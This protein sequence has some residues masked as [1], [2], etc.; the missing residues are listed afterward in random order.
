[1]KNLFFILALLTGLTVTKAQAQTADA[2]VTWSKVVNASADDVWT[3][4]REMDD[5]NKYSSGISKVVW[6]GNKGKGGERIC[7]PPKGQEGYFKEKIVD[8]NDNGRTFSYSVLEGIP[9][10]GMVNT[11]KVVDL[12]YQKS[13]IVWSSEF[14]EFMKNPQMTEEQFLGF[15]YMSL[16]EMVNN[17][18]MATKKMK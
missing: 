8:F 14:D 3:L 5:I 6:K 7:Y 15:I 13:M 1:M 18:Y 4:L 9:V 12:G 10:K 11:F 2:N 17:I 16:E